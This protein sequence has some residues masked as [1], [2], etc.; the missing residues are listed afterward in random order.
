[1]RKRRTLVQKPTTHTH[2]PADVATRGAVRQ[3]GEPTHAAEAVA[4]VKRARV[5]DGRAVRA[6]PNR[7]RAADGRGR[8]AGER[9]KPDRARRQRRRARKRRR[10]HAVAACALARAVDGARASRRRT[11]IET[12]ARRA[13]RQSVRDAYAVLTATRTRIP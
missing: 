4:Q 8:R 3:F 7:V 5:G 6:L 13:R 2:T 11:A 12:E 1:M 10:R 9:R